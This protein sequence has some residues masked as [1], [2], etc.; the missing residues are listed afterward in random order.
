MSKKQK[1]VT[2][3]SKSHQFFKNMHLN[4]E[5]IFFSEVAKYALLEAKEA[6]LSRDGVKAMEIINNMLIAERE[7]REKHGQQYS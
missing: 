1:T 6:L 2:E 7:N 4:D 3:K 5:K